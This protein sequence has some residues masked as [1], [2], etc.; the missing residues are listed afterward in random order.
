MCGRVLEDMKTCT[1][2]TSAYALTDVDMDYRSC[3]FVY[4]V[5]FS[6]GMQQPVIFLTIYLRIVGRLT[7][8]TLSISNIFV[9]I[10]SLL[11]CV[12]RYLTSVSQ[13]NMV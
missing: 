9:I 5:I 12:H 2:N 11:V 4:V 1:S 7:P 6:E 8:P 3:C 13:R 10:L